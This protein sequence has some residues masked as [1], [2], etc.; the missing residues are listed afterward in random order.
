[1]EQSL[2]CF[3]STQCQFGT[4]PQGDVGRLHSL[5]NHPHQI[6]AHC[7]QVRLV[8]QPGGERLK[9]LP[10]V[11]LLAVEPTVDERLDATTQ[12]S[13]QGCDQEGRSHYRKRPSHKVRVLSASW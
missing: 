4:Q 6:V 1:M 2:R 7:L 11:V 13:E 12:R 3:S 9:G 5:P 8:P 10:G